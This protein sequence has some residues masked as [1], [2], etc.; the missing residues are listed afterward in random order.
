MGF[1]LPSVDLDR[2]LAPGVTLSKGKAY[3]KCGDQKDRAHKNGYV[4]YYNPTKNF[5]FIGRD[6]GGKDLFAHCSDIEDGQ[7]LAKGDAV[8]YIR[9]MDD[10]GRPK[11]ASISGGTG[12]PL[13]KT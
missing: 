4:T 2:Q 9:A 13:D 12:G 5:G 1:W 11:A 10:K 3:S 8:R 6:E 7:Q